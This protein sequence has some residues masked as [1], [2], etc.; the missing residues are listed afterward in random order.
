MVI[1]LPL[2]AY[3]RVN[4]LV[5]ELHDL[6]VKVGVTPD[7]F[8]LALHKALIE[9][10]AGIPILDLR[11]PALNDYLLMVERAFELVVTVILFPPELILMGVIAIALRM[12]GPGPILFQ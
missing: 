7:Y 11:A 5:T 4:S 10:F 3:K 9:E 8:Q 1:A 2:R 6:P 12:E